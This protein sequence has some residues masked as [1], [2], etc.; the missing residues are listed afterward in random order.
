MSLS[1]QKGGILGA[2]MS[3]V[4]VARDATAAERSA[5]NKLLGFSEAKMMFVGYTD[6][7]GES[8]T[9]LVFEV[10]GEYWTTSDSEAW[11]RDKLRPPSDWLLAQLAAARQQKEESSKP[12][13][14]PAQDSVDVLDLV[15]P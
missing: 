3:G 15:G 7:R 13:E 5:P 2:R 14:I 10:K 9:I 6:Q 8:Q 1:N 11:C 4:K 12:V